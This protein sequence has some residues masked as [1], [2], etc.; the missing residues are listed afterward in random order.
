M[1]LEGE[2][3]VSVERFSGSSV[4]QTCFNLVRACRSPAAGTLQLHAQ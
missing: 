2:D 1:Q 3:D 4:S